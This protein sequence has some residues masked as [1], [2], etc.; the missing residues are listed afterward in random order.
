MESE[1]LTV[2]IPT[3]DRL[4]ATN[5]AIA[6]IVTIQ[7]N[8]VDVIIVDDNGSK[9]Y[10]PPIRTRTD[11]IRIQV[12]RNRLNVGAGLSRLVGVTASSTNYIAFLDSDDVFSDTWIDSVLEAIKNHHAKKD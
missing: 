5:R 4:V 3:F 7:P 8:F 1:R 9:I 2:V 10:E 11:T 6:S 12:I